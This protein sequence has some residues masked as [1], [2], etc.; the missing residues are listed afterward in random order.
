MNSHKSYLRYEDEDVQTYL[1][2][3][4]HLGFKP[5]K[6]GTKKVETQEVPVEA[7]KDMLI[8]IEKELPKVYRRIIEGEKKVTVFVGGHKIVAYRI[9]GQSLVRIDIRGD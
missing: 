1:K 9:G 6:K 3:M 5:D 8:F 2:R 4:K 7:S